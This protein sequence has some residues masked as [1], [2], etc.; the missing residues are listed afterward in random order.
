MSTKNVLIPLELTAAASAADAGILK[1]KNGIWNN[2]FNN[3]KWT[4][5]WYKENYSSSW[6]F[7]ILLKGITKTIKNETKLEKE[8]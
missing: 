6:R 8:M 3:F 2:N 4:H 1:K 5:E 7:N